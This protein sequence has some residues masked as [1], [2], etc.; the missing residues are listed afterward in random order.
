M[1]ALVA[2]KMK[3]MRERKSR[4]CKVEKERRQHGI[5]MADMAEPRGGYLGN[6]SYKKGQAKATLPQRVAKQASDNGYMCLRL[7]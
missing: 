2:D 3:M 7:V 6:R 5:A 1:A 4:S